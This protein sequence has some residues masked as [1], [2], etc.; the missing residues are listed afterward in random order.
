MKSAIKTTILF[1]SLTLLISSCC[2]SRVE[3]YRT[4]MWAEVKIS[5][6][7]VRDSVKISGAREIKSSGKIYTIG[8][9]I[10]ISEKN[11]GV[12]IID[13]SNPTQPKNISFITIPGNG[14]I[15]V[16]NNY[17]YADSY[18]DLLTFDISNPASPKFEKR[19]D[20]IFNST[21]TSEWAHLDEKT[22]MLSTYK[23]V[24]TIITYTI[25]DCNDYSVSP[26]D[27]S[28][29]GGATNNASKSGSGSS[30]KGGSMARF[31]IYDKYL[32]TV[33][34]TALQTFDI[35]NPA[36]PKAWAQINIGWNIETIYPFKGKLFIGSRTGMFIYDV[37]TP[38]NPTYISQ[39]NHFRACDPVVADDKYA[40]V[41]L[42]GGNNCGNNLNQL[43]IIDISNIFDPKL[44]KSYPM[45]GP[46]GV[47]I[48]DEILFVCDS[49]A[50][51]KVF[52]ASKPDD[53]KL[54]DWESD[55]NTYD[56][57]PMGKRAIVV[58]EDGIYQY[59]YSNPKDMKLISKIPFIK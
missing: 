32:Y 49:K 40:Y 45:Q 16:K 27:R 23:L 1:L 7:K 3:T 59:D 43:D 10:L 47:G 36:N 14:D 22:N 57:I 30:G 41:T 35:E 58:A 24:D 28:F 8:N 53:I 46:L 52:D 33:C 38:W 48:D 55:F 11:A 12:H 29:E 51:L 44:I 26:V 2:T 20:A 31:T 39:F 4:Q 17:L 54:L 15:A 37:S 42:K 5:M 25:N 9:Y 13:N 56:I 21:L 19:V 6:D 50:G 18:V 34:N